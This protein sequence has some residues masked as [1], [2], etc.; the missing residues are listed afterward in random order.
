M[1]RLLPIIAIATISTAPAHA[2]ASFFGSQDQASVRKECL[3]L[4]DSIATGLAEEM[5]R[6]GKNCDIATKKKPNIWDLIK[7]APM[8]RYTVAYIATGNYNPK[9]PHLED[10][11][12]MLRSH[13]RAPKVVWVLPYDR[14]AAQ[15][16][17]MNAAETGGLV[18]DMAWWPT[19]DGLH[20][21]DYRPMAEMIVK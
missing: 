11:A 12:R 1:R 9:N 16:I 2:Q 7:L 21:V 17:S 8:Q 20:P 5:Q 15:A 14:T 3:I 18:V 10:E 6:Q 13:I 4:G 19:R